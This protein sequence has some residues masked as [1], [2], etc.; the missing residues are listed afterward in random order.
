MRSRACGGPFDHQQRYQQRQGDE[1]SLVGSAQ[2]GSSHCCM[3]VACLSCHRHCQ[4]CSEDQHLKGLG[5]EGS[6]PEQI[7]MI[8]DN[9]PLLTKAISTKPKDDLHS[10]KA[11]IVLTYCSLDFGS[12]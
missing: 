12:L 10:L 3:L 1:D 4:Q 11:T 8:V 6:F 7:Q 2:S 9:Q 5:L